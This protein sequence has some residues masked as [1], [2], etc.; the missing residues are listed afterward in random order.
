MAKEKPLKETKEEVKE[1]KVEK[2]IKVK[3]TKDYFAIVDGKEVSG[4][5]D[6]EIVLPLNHFKRKVKYYT[7]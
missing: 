7:F 1:T 6:E 4:K 3:L 5:A 2:T